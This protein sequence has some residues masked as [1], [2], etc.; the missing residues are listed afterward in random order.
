MFTKTEEQEQE[1][2]YGGKEEERRKQIVSPKLSSSSIYALKNKTKTIKSP[3]QMVFNR[4]GG[5][6]K[7]LAFQQNID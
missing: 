3:H 1:Q 7:R 5:G 2:G 6:E 4:E